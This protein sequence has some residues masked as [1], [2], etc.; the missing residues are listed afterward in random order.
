MSNPFWSLQLALASATM[1]TVYILSWPL[2]ALFLPLSVRLLAYKFVRG[3]PVPREKDIK[4]NGIP[5]WVE[6]QLTKFSQVP[7]FVCWVGVRHCCRSQGPMQPI[8]LNGVGRKWAIGTQ[9][10][11]HNALC[12]AA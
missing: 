2:S 10:T 4:F 1:G 11:T 12:A 8:G 9:C 5:I 6:K 7:Y 3:P